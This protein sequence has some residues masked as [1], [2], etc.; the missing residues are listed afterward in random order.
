MSKS[1]F[2]ACVVAITILT[3]T[4]NVKTVHSLMPCQEALTVFKPCLAYL[5]AS[6]GVKPTPECC[7]GLD[8]INRGAKTYDDRRDMWNCLSSAAPD[9]NK[10]VTLPQLCGVTYSHL[11]GPKF[12]CN[13]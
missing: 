5:H 13:R 3:S 12:D 1:I 11:I 6:P 8:N 2:I 10:L 9:P 4:L 7:K